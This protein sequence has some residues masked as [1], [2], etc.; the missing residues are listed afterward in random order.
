MSSCS[1]LGISCVPYFPPFCHHIAIAIALLQKSSLPFKGGGDSLQ[2]PH[3]LKTGF[4]P[5]W[6]TNWLSI[7]LISTVPPPSKD[8]SAGATLTHL[9]YHFSPHFTSIIFNLFS[10]LPPFHL[11]LHN[12][13][14]ISPLNFLHLSSRRKEKKRERCRLT[15]SLCLLVLF[16]FQE[17]NSLKSTSPISLPTS[18]DVSLLP[19]STGW[20]TLV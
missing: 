9:I 18:V 14:P 6:L 11:S 20:A 12:G 8:H 13:F 19:V 15:F 3:N 7:L 4:L 5:L 16:Q 17:E 1:P 2:L 10:C